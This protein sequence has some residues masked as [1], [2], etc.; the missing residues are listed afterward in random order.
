ME[1]ANL[2][3]II[4]LTLTRPKKCSLT[5]PMSCSS[6]DVFAPCKADKIYT[7]SS[8]VCILTFALSNN[9]VIWLFFMQ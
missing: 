1:S 7:V 6:D 9:Y 8:S 2:N 5:G 4:K 3:R